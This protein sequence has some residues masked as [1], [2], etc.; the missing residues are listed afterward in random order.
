[1]EQFLK[2]YKSHSTVK[3]IL[4]HPSFLFISL[5]GSQ[6]LSSYFKMCP[7]I[8]SAQFLTLN[9]FIGLFFWSQLTLTYEA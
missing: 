7:L 6:A 5:K 9:I 1:M 3:K 8:F 2:S 4:S